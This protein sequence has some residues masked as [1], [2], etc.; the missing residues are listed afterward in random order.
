MIPIDLVTDGNWPVAALCPQALTPQQ[1]DILYSLLP[2]ESFRHPALAGRWALAEVL[3]PQAW[4]N[5]QAKR[6]PMLKPRCVRVNFP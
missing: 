3:A 1:R 4:A 5:E 6:T 2:A